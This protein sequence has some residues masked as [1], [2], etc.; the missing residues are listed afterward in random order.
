M[1]MASK[2]IKQAPSFPT[3]PQTVFKAWMDSKS[4]SAM[5]GDGQ[6][7][8]NSRVGGSF[9]IWDGAIVGKTLQI[10]PKKRRIVQSWRYS[11][12][13]WPKDKPSK[14][15]LEFIIDKSNPEHTRLRFWHSGIPEKYAVD[16]AKGWKDY[17]WKPMRAYF[18]K[19]Q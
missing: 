7:K 12:D 18:S 2:N 3:D 4:H 13:D 11:Y 19:K 8:I 1:G 17:Y 5:L 14:I 10:D 9:S 16:I 6:A 15:T